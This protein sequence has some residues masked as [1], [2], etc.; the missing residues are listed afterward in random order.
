MD[1]FL[2]TMGMMGNKLGATD[3]AFA[4]MKMSVGF[5]MRQFKAL[6]E[7]ALILLGEALEPLVS[8]IVKLGTQALTAFNKLPKAVKSAMVIVPLLGGIAAVVAGGLLL[9]AGSAISAA[10]S[11]GALEVALAPLLIGLAAAAGAMLFLGVVA[12]GFFV[13]FKKNVGGFGDAVSDAF[14]KV[15]LVFEVFSQMITNDGKITGDV[16]KRLMDKNNRSVLAFVQ[17]VH[18]AWIRLKTFLKGIKDGFEESLKFAGPVFESLVDAFLDLGRALGIVDAKAGGFEG[19]L[20]GFAQAGELVGQALAFMVTTA[21]RAITWFTRM[22]TGMVKGWKSFGQVFDF[23]GTLVSEMFGGLMDDIDR[24]F[25]SLSIAGEEGEGFGSI[26]EWLGRVMGQTLAAAA[27]V[28]GGVL[29]VVIFM[30]RVGVKTVQL[31]VDVFSSLTHAVGETWKRMKAAF[32]EGLPSTLA[33]FRAQVYAVFLPMA[34]FFAKWADV[35]MAQVDRVIL[36]VKGVTNKLAFLPG[37]GSEEDTAITAAAREREAARAQGVNPLQRAL[38]ANFDDIASR[39]AKAE[40]GAKGAA[41]AR[42]SERADALTGALSAIANKG[43]GDGGVG[44]TVVVM[45]G[46]KVGRLIK[47]AS[48]R[49]AARESR[50]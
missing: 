27:T 45:D 42:A 38:S 2:E 48:T 43:S 7:S 36:G 29:S 44:D 21:V 22:T 28:L 15:K 3:E 39:G 23:V 26:M 49:S 14:E 13:A 31:M 24:L 4:K 40:A 33:G 34:E 35:I 10:T 25:V 46:E 37:F 5:Q 1:K 18:S 16:L 20:E 19:G 17:N 41:E 8:M 47:A 32:G 11:I 30:I 50:G 12:T 6:K 9:L